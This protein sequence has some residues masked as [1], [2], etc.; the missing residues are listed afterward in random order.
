MRPERGTRRHS[1]AS[2]A[3]CV[4]LAGFVSGL[5][6]CAATSPPPGSAGRSRPQV[7]RPA[8]SDTNGPVVA[9][10]GSHRITRHEIDSLLATAPQ[11]VR[12]QYTSDREQYKQLVERIAEQEALYQAAVQ[13]GTESDSSYRAEV[14]GHA[15]QLLVKHYYQNAVRTLPA[16]PDSLV[17]LYY[18]EHASEFKVSGRA[19]VRH[20]LLPTRAK[21]AQVLKRLKA[22]DS[23]DPLCARYSTDKGSAKTGGV[24]GLVVSDADVVPGF[25]NAPSI[26][27]AAFRLKEGETSEPLKT[28]RGWHIIRVDQVTP[29]GE[30]KFESVEKQIRSSLES[31]RAEAFQTALLD[32]LKQRYGTT[33]FDDSLELA[34]SPAKSP[35]DLFQAAQAAGS[36]RERIDLFRKVVARYPTDK[37]APQAQFMIGFSYAEELSQYPEAR[38]AFQEFLRK[39]PNS[40]LVESAKWML[41]NMESSSLPPGLGAAGD[42]TGAAGDSTGAVVVPADPPGGTDTKP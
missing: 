9:I 41:E 11:S 39:F 20:I 2:L 24:I 33:V 34:L 29:A 4:V 15:R 31:D 28:D 1:G 14:A 42:S 23:W 16:V 3:G 25:G 27:E 5:W 35:A 18:D 13:A 26:V 19:R 30:Q 10:V 37:S 36:S 12:D 40:D 21:A 8:A 22:G 38:E 32:S 17:H 6:G 7:W